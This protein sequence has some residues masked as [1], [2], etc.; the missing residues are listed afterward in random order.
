M[1]EVCIMCGIDMAEGMSIC[2][3]CGA[4]NR[5]NVNP[6]CKACEDRML[7]CQSTCKRYATWS[8][9]RNKMKSDI[10][11]IKDIEYGLKLRRKDL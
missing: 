11:Q 2:P 8:R 10:R 5:P 3:A 1:T 7:R 4:N 6:P 9:R